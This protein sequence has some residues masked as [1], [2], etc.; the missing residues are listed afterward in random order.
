M[1]VK[2]LG[3]DWLFLIYCLLE[4]EKKKVPYCSFSI[5]IKVHVFLGL[6]LIILFEGTK[7]KNSQLLRRP[8]RSWWSNSHFIVFSHTRSTIQLCSQFQPF[9]WP[10]VSCDYC[11]CVVS[12]SVSSSSPSFTSQ[13]SSPSNDGHF[14]RRWEKYGWITDR[15]AFEKIKWSVRNRLDVWLNWIQFWNE[16][17]SKKKRWRRLILSNDLKLLR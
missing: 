15:E 1:A 12:F 11:M 4:R 9:E 10:I 14:W 13:T 3:N 17:T 16:T 8:Q 7:K 5:R 2:G 6:I